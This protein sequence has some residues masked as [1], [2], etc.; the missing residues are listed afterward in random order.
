MNAQDQAVIAEAM[1]RANPDIEGDLM[2]WIER[3]DPSTAVK[4]R[5][6]LDALRSGS[7]EDAQNGGAT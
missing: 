6:Y 5:E 1:K 2:R 4:M 3:L 7:R